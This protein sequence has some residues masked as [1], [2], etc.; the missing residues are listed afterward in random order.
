M[1]ELEIDGIVGSYQGA[2]PRYV[3]ITKEQWQNRK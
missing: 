3:L 1:D 2:R